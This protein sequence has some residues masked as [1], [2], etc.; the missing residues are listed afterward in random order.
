M[1]V[2][3]LFVIEA[4]FLS[5]L[6]RLYLTFAPF[7]SFVTDNSIFSSELNLISPFRPI[8]CIS[9]PFFETLNKLSLLK[10]PNFWLIFVISSLFLVI[11]FVFFVMFSFV[12]YNWEPFIASL[13]FLLTSPAFKFVMVTPP[14]TFGFALLSSPPRVILSLAS[15]S[16]LTTFLIPAFSWATLTAS[17]SCVPAA[18]FV[19]WRVKGFTLFPFSSSPS[20]SEP[21]DIAPFVLAAVAATSALLP[22]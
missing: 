4:M 9:A 8:S 19:I 6:F 5:S 18:T 17:A 22:K 10:S 3:L 20:F 7:P 1:Y 12:V 21:T 16:Y 13:L 14:A 11:L 15:L 2:L